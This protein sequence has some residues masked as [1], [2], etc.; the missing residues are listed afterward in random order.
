ML[1][2]SGATHS[3]RPARND[4]EWP[5]AEPTEVSLADGVTQSLRLKPGTRSLLS[6]PQ[7][8]KFKSWILPLGGLTDMGFKFEW[9]G[10]AA[11]T[12]HDPAHYGVQ[13]SIHQGCGWR[14]PDDEVGELLPANG[15]ARDGPQH[16]PSK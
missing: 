10:Q 11:C 8:E 7:E 4:D 13:V 3:F 6:N 16:D 15:A 1:P 9:S 5:C 14:S 2:D 12:L